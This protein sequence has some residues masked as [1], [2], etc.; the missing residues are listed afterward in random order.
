MAFTVSD[1]KSNLKGGG[2]RPS[3]FSVNLSYPTGIS[4][5]SLKSEFLIKGTTIPASTLGTYEIF[6]HG[7]GIK[8]AGDRTFDTWDTTIINDE[9]L[10][11][12]KH[13]KIG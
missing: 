5:D 6:F 11:L 10:V 3:L 2:A 9:D 12:E 13:L 7:K 8:V 1:F 4:K